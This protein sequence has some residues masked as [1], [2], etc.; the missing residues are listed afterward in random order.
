MKTTAVPASPIL[1]VVVSPTST[2]ATITRLRPDVPEGRER[3]LPLPAVGVE[4]R[5]PVPH[6]LLVA[7]QE[8]E[9]HVD[10]RMPS[11]DPE[12]LPQV[13]GLLLVGHAEEL[14]LRR[15]LVAVLGD[16]QPLLAVEPGELPDEV[17]DVAEHDR[18]VRLRA[19]GRRLRAG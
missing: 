3:R 13:G 1:F 4:A 8:P 10:A 16:P 14:V 6:R 15:R 18:R 2:G 17:V 7:D 19:T 11:S 12:R 9:H 5:P